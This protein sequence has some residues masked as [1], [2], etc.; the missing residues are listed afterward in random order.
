MVNRKVYYG[1]GGTVLHAHMGIDKCA[2]PPKNEL[3][4]LAA[5]WAGETVLQVPVAR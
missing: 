3:G 2:S 5:C 1:V 4:D